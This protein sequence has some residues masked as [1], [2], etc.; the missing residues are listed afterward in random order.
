ML[1]RDE[2]AAAAPKATEAPSSNWWGSL[3]QAAK[4]MVIIFLL[5]KWIKSF[6]QL[7]LNECSL[8]EMLASFC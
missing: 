4:E 8:S 6:N 1:W 5:L 3:F 7:N 2:A